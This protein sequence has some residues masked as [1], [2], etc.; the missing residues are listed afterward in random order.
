[1]SIFIY[2]S[3]LL[4][5]IMSIAL[6]YNFLGKAISKR[7]KGTFI[8]VGTAIMYGLVTLVYMISSKKLNLGLNC[9][10]CK[11]LIIYSFVPLNSICIL[12]YLAKSYRLWKNKKI[13]LDNYK[14]RC[15]ILTI[16]LIAILIFEFFYF[17]GIQIKIV[18]IMQ[19][20]RI[21]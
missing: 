11:N 5:N 16:I 2:L 17:Q 8:I 18:E 10:K 21:K 20:A 15:I 9:E 7:N 6:I 12:P 4:L 13:K 19:N 14:K 3:I 1:M